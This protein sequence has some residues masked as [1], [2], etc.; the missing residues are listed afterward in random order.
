MCKICSGRKKGVW[1]LIWPNSD[2]YFYWTWRQARV[3]QAV[4]CQVHKVGNYSHSPAIL[5][6]SVFC[7]LLLSSLP[8]GSWLS[9]SNSC[10]GFFWLLT[11]IQFSS[12]AWIYWFWSALCDCQTL[13]HH[14]FMNPPL[15][16]RYALVTYSS[17]PSPYPPME[18]SSQELC[19]P[20]GCLMGQNEYVVYCFLLKRRIS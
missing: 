6:I 18:L 8:L 15:P 17:A 4:H 5:P 20:S 19:W 7:L 9:A 16:V 3:K 13:S 12:A 14:D 2:L 11:K 1:L 10:L